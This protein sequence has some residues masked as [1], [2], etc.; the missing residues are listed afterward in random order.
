MD[1]NASIIDQQVRG[2]ADR[3]LDRITGNE[4]QRHSRAFVV[5]CVKTRLDLDE[6]EALDCLTDGGHDADIDGIHLADVKSREFK[7]T[8]FQGKYKKALDGQAGFPGNSIKKIIG[9]IGAL[10]DPDKPISVRNELQVVVEEIRSLVRDG[11]FPMVHVVLCNNGRRWGAD[12]D[13]LIKNSGLPASQ[14]SWEHF[15]HDRLVQLIQQTRSVKDRLH[16][17][18]ES[19]V[20]EFDFRR[21]LI[22]KVHVREIKE[23]FDRHGDLLLERNIRRYLGLHDNRVNQAIRTTLTDPARRSNFYFY[24]NGITAICDKFRHNALQGKNHVLDVEGLQ[25]INGGQTCK[26][27]QNTLSE[28]MI[29]ESSQ[30]F[31]LLRLY[32]VQATED[33]VNEITYATNSQNPVDL[34]DLRSNNELQQ[35]LELGIRGLGYEYRRKRDDAP[36]TPSTVTASAAAE[37]VLAIWRRKPH[38]AR[39]RGRELFGDLYPEIFTQDLNAA[40]TIL[41]VLILHMVERDCRTS[42]SLATLRHAL[43][44]SHVLAMLVGAALLARAGLT[45]AAINHTNFASLKANLET[46]YAA[47]SGEAQRQLEAALSRLGISDATSLQR[48]AATFRRGDLLE[49]LQPGRA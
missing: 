41:A 25:V 36:P 30:A 34:R 43:Y 7:V 46:H 19:M 15:N 42:F 28:S 11:N 5:L 2:L 17:V 13:E 49:E 32:E 4:E 35:R 44:A 48:L 21:V 45:L 26:T 3:R 6:D 24:N 16:L 40:Q 18:G 29:D 8:L 1:F 39:L 47:L 12:G 10:F 23:L 33:I 27:I 20:D 38:L 37:A 22:G 9:T 31:V 14:V